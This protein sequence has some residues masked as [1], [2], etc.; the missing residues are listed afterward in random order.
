MDPRMLRVVC[1]LGL[2]PV[3]SGA[4]ADPSQTPLSPPSAEEI[5]T[6]A[7]EV[8]NPQFDY[9]VWVD[10][11]SSK[12][13]R[14]PQRAR[15]EVLVKGRDRT[16]IKTLSPA[17]D[18]GR[19]LLMRGRDLWAFL[20]TI[21][22][23]LRISLQERLIGEVA[24]G[25]LARTNFSGDYAPALMETESLHGSA[26]YV[27]NLTAL[28]ENVTYARVVLRVEDTTFY[29]LQ[30][31]FYALSGRHLKTCRYEAYAEMAGRLRPT[32]LIMQD[33]VSEGQYSVIEYQRMELTPLPDKFFTKDYLKR[34]P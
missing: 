14:A 30:A 5:L 2:L 21:S 17:V 3:M 12:P 15:Y 6:K 32:R 24:N 1:L 16:V 34:M 25:D 11:T 19:L 22:K 20:P 4:A 7:D 31:E 13:Q 8:R 29:P 18:R 23:P 10:V 9:M 28:H 27:L 33:A 26:V